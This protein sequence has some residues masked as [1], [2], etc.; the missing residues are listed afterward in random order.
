MGQHDVAR[1][2]WRSEPPR[3]REERAC[4]RQVT[5][6]QHRQAGWLGVEMATLSWPAD[7]D[8]KDDLEAFL[9]NGWDSGRSEPGSQILGYASGMRMQMM[10]SRIGP[11]VAA[12]VALS[13]IGMSASPAEARPKISFTA[14]GTGP[15]YAMAAGVSETIMGPTGG[16]LVSTDDSVASFGSAGAIPSGRATLRALSP[17]ATTI[18]LLVDGRVADEL[19]VEVEVSSPTEID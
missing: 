9:F 10:I 18:Q 2:G 1:R 13:S 14:T 8:R 3:R 4:A 17:G 16:R 19:E 12:L 15:R 5:D 7:L 6:K 11:S